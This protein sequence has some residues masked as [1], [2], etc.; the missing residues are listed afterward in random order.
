MEVPGHPG[1]QLALGT[2]EGLHLRAGSHFEP[3][4]FGWEGGD[5]GGGPVYTTTLCCLMLEVYYRY[6]PT[7]KHVESAPDVA[8]PKT[9]DVVVNVVK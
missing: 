7:F 9:D 4:I 1:S 8:P 5:H 3:E 2:G 6:L